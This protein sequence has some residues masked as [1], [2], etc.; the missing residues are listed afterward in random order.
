LWTTFAVITGDVELLLI[1]V[2]GNAVPSA[3]AAAPK[4]LP[5]VITLCLFLLNKLRTLLPCSGT[6][7]INLFS[8]FTL[9]FIF[10]SCMIKKIIS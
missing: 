9:F 10:F 5:I 6:R 8:G 2:S 1:K 4:I 3:M 7:Q